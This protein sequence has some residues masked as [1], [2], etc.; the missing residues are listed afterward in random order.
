MRLG[1]KRRGAAA[2]T[3]VPAADFDGLSWT[4]LRR[5]A[6]AHGVPTHQ[7]SRAAITAALSAKA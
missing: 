1:S 6:K 7:R 4:E 3:A 5:V 2:P